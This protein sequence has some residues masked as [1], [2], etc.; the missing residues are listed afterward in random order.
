MRSISS[1]LYR[2]PDQL[3]KEIIVMDDF[4]DIPDLYENVSNSIRSLSSKIQLVRLPERNGL[5]RARI[6]ASRRATGDVSG[7]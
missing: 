3:L 4:S 5:I 1:I 2:T 6:F 7:I